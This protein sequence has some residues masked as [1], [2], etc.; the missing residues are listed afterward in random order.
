MRKLVLTSKIQWMLSWNCLW[1]MKSNGVDLQ[2]FDT[3]DSAY[4]YAE[5]L[6]NPLIVVHTGVYT[7]EFLVIDSSVTIIGAGMLHKR[8]V[9][10][11]CCW[12]Y[13][14]WYS[15]A[16]WHRPSYQFMPRSP[17]AKFF[18]AR[19]FCNV[20]SVVIVLSSGTQC[21]HFL[22]NSSLFGHFSHWLHSRKCA[23]VH[24]DSP[25]ILPNWQGV[26]AKSACPLHYNIV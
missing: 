16:I 8:N 24:L 4:N 12:I 19:N 2:Y 21:L 26:W 11:C 15:I 14:D 5:D 10:P 25:F 22:D 1:L 3:I 17:A 20:G 23:V 9:L 7:R 13:L 18:K 6:E